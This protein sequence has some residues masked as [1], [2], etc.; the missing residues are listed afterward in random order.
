MIGTLQLADPVW[1][2][3]P[4]GLLGLGDASGCLRVWWIA[5]FGGSGRVCWVDGSD[6]LTACR[7]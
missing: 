7:G 4:G 5:G 2:K 6:R 1:A 3:P